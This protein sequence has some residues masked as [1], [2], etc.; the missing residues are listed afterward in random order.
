MTESDERIFVQIASYRDRECQWTIKDLFEK[1]ANPDRIFV[2]VC[3]QHDPKEDADCFLVETRP[4]QVRIADYHIREAQGL[5]WARQKAQDLWDGEEYFLQIDSHM[6]FDQD[7]DQKMIEMLKLTP[8]KWPVLTVYP[9]CYTP[10]NDLEE[11]PVLRIQAP[12]EFNDNGIL[13]FTAQMVPSH[14][15]TDKPFPT[16]SLAGGFIFGPSRIVEKLQHDPQIYFFGEEVS[17]AVRLWTHGF[18]LY[19]PNQQVI[20]HYYE[21]KEGLRHWDDNKEWSENELRSLMRLRQLLE[22]SNVDSFRY[23]ED[24]GVYGLGEERSLAEYE[25]FAGVNFTGK[26]IAQHAKGYPYVLTEE[27][28]ASILQQTQ[29]KLSE[30]AHLFILDD[31]GVVFLDKTGDFALLNSAATYAWC[32]LEEG[33]SFAD[34]VDAME[35]Q[36]ATTRAKAEQMVAGLLTHWQGLGLLVDP[37]DDVT[38]PPL[39]ADNRQV[40]PADSGSPRSPGEQA[41]K[42]KHYYRLLDSVIEIRFGAKD[43]EKWIHPVLAHLEV[44]PSEPKHVMTTVKLKDFYSLY[45]DGVPETSCW[46]IE[47]LAPLAKF[48]VLTLAIDDYDYSLNLH[49]GVVSDGKSCVL[50]PAAAGSGKTSLTAALAHAGYTYFSDETALLESDTCRVR[51]VPLAFTVKTTGTQALESRYPELKD[52]AVHERGDGKRVQY[53]LPH[54]IPTASQDVATPVSAIIFPEYR[55]EAETLLAPVTKVEALGRI[56]RHSVQI[57]KRMTLQDAVTLVQWIR[58]MESFDL[59]YS[60]LDE[61]VPLVSQVFNTVPMAPKAMAGGELPQSQGM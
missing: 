10:P 56:L 48:R 29:M 20:Y 43:H 28:S 22:P 13:N 14:V 35:Q 8:S 51:P 54:A 61:A 52:L 6:R 46:K 38:V 58:R 44:A 55:A 60:S 24:L 23:K 21:R 18:D 25:Q 50:L 7:W 26:T 34:L 12:E 42:A 57:P 37:Q 47:E 4:D 32:L 2:G 45:V 11:S 17:L 27:V 53:V 3:W 5:G 33:A 41:A 30:Q 31:Q 40:P 15:P 9:A 49:A 39:H 36:L 59:V 19:S 16:A 1:A